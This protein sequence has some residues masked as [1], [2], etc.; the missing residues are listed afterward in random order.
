MRTDP[1]ALALAVKAITPKEWRSLA[2][3]VSAGPMPWAL[4]RARLL[5]IARVIEGR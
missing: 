4:L 5:K 1:V 3:R 2:M